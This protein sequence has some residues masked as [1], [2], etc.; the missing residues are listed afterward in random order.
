[1]AGRKK[2]YYRQLFVTL[3]SDEEEFKSIVNKLG[4]K[5]LLEE[6]INRTIGNEWFRTKITQDVKDR[7][8]Y[9]DS[10][11]PIAQMLV[12]KYQNTTKPYWTKEDIN[13]ATE[14]ISERIMNFIFEQ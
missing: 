6:K 14:K 5:I 13:N 8:G 11:Y 4:N 2:S 3:I 9:K 12:E 10:C 1:M 7:I